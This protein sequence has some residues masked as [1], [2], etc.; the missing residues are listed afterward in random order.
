M[1]L[2]V[3]Y[4]DIV[5]TGFRMLQYNFVNSS[6]EPWMPDHLTL[7]D[8]DLYNLTTKPI[9]TI[10]VDG[11]EAERSLYETTR[12]NPLSIKFHATGKNVISIYHSHFI[13]YYCQYLFLYILK[14]IL[15]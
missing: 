15:V 13:Y 14:F 6:G 2:K 3:N 11:N 10:K 7:Y 12:S 4:F 8:G 1:N 9:V 5:F